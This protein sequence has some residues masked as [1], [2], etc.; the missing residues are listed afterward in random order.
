MILIM[1]KTKLLPAVLV[2]LINFLIFNSSTL[3][4][5]EF[6]VVNNEAFTVGEKLT[7]ESFTGLQIHIPDNTS[8]KFLHFTIVPQYLNCWDFEFYLTLFTLI[9]TKKLNKN[10]TSSLNRHHAQFHPV[11]GIGSALLSWISFAN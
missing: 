7:F 6:R 3:S 5:E 8:W 1:R 10:L 9:G 4:Q 11:N 2:I